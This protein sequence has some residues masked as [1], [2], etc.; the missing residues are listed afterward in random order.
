M[1]FKI[2]DTN[3]TEK[4]IEIVVP[5]EEL[6]PHFEK[7][8]QDYQKKIDMPG[9]RKGKVPLDKIKKLYG[10]SI[11]YESLEKIAN[12]S[13]HKTMEEQNIDVIGTPALVDMNY[14]KG[15]EATFKVKYEVI[16]NF[17]LKNYKGLKYEKFV[18]NVTE[19]EFEDQLSRILFAN[20][21]RS[22]VQ[23]ASDDHH[24]VTFDIQDLDES[25]APLIGKV[26]KNETV[27]L[28]DKHVYPE[29]KNTL[30]NVSVNEIRIADF[31]YEHDGHKHKQ[32]SQLSVTKIQK[33]V[34]P[35]L[36]DEFVKK[37]TKDAIL[38]V[39]DFK[40]HLRENLQIEWQNHNESKLINTIVEK[41]VGSHEFVV[42]ASLIEGVLNSFVE[43]I[44]QRFPNKELPKE[45]NIEEFKKH[46]K[47]RATWQAKWFLIR[48]QIIK[49]ENLKVEDSDIE[50][51]VDAD[52][53]R[54][55]I[56]R[57]RLM[58]Y[59]KKAQTVIDGILS[60]KLNKFLIENNEI[61]EIVTDT[62]I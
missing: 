24:V 25:G 59:Y 28:A 23:T 17:D 47:E 20:A 29:F 39:D 60:V 52:A 32:K 5:Q 30:K 27:Y 50:E 40:K 55:G 41:I 2:T 38:T 14:K 7:A 18:H 16:P 13:F 4:E 43:D 37:I 33:V 3:E 57:E 31:D 26:A 42:P 54:T 35:E 8:F 9:F 34:L 21:E 6:I 53:K 15:E 61:E 45:F 11:E 10:D 1:N 19:E 51:R 48:E 46:Q 12:D 58:E 49:T 22:D 62:E 44:K 36:N 56:D